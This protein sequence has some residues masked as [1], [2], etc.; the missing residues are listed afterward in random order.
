[1][2]YWYSGAICIAILALQFCKSTPLRQGS[3]TQIKNYGTD[4][5]EAYISFDSH[6]YMPLSQ[7]P[8]SQS[9]FDTATDR[10]AKSTLEYLFGVFQFHPPFD[11]LQGIPFGN[12]S[13]KIDS[14]MNP[15]AS[16]IVVY[17]GKRMQKIKYHF[18]DKGLFRK[19]LFL[20]EDQP[21]LVELRLPLDIDSIYGL[22]VIQ[23]E[24]GGKMVA[25]KPCTDSHYDGANDF[26][27]FW[28]P[29]KS[30]CPD[31]LKTEGTTLVQALLTPL[32]NTEVT[33]PE[34]GRLGTESELTVYV[35]NA[36]NGAKVAI[37][38]APESMNEATRAAYDGDAGVKAYKSFLQRMEQL[39]FKISPVSHRRHTLTATVKGR[40]VTVHAGL[41]K[42]SV[43][44]SNTAIK[45]EFENFIRDAMNLGDV[46]IYNGHS[47][48]GGT[49]PVKR[50]A[51]EPGTLSIPD[52]Y[53]I[54]FFNGC[55]TYAY[56]RDA[57]F[58]QKAGGTKNLDIVSTGLE[59]YFGMQHLVTSNLIF[60][61]MNR[62]QTWQ[63]IVDDLYKAASTLGFDT[64]KHAS[65]YSVNGD[66]D[67][68]T[69][70]EAAL[71]PR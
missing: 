54:Y 22:G 28:N 7:S 40:L 33:Y 15:G 53:Q 39:A 66:E 12:P 55:S 29:A 17:Q 68:P 45:E 37:E 70:L 69:T 3:F 42:S 71:R 20:S 41:F 59:S 6:F 21:K 60:Y 27:Y 38:P 19:S 43:R 50:F 11:K 9:E 14:T 25:K 44:E 24:E 65:H 10:R 52:K 1:M 31:I 34:Y 51:R 63:F 46:F 16:E 30:G 18:N 5:V 2:R 48:L 23:V 8:R 67:N 32:P 13:W 64:V 56:Y 36:A 26:W 58:D 62:Q 4:N 61:L 47:G 57:Y 49:L 35:A